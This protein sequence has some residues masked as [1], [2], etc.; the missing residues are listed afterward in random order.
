M[1]QPFVGQ[2]IAV[3]FSYTPSGWLPCQ[4]GLYPISQYQTLYTLLGTT[5][6]GDGINTFGVPN[7]SGRTPLNYGQGQGLSA[8]VTGQQIGGESVTLTSNQMPPHNHTLN[9]ST[10]LATTVTPSAG[11]AVATLPGTAAVNIYATAAPNSALNAGSIVAGGG[12]SQPHENRQPFLVIN[13]IIAHSGVFP[14]QN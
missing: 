14:S 2:I 9:F 7:L 3:A 5:Y 8:Y 4:G 1:A 12:G 10:S 13:Y 11:Q 6:G